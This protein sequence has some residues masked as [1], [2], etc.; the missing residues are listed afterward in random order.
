[1]SLAVKDGNSLK[2]HIEDAIR[3]LE[4]GDFWAREI[5]VDASEPIAYPVTTTLYERGYRPVNFSPDNEL[6]MAHLSEKAGNY[7]MT[8]ETMEL[9]E[10][11][12]LD[13]EVVEEGEL[14]NTVNF[15]PGE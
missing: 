4:I 7:K 9:V 3:E 2:K 15:L 5:N 6:R 11:T 12:G 14:S 1:M 8:P 10:E 13:F